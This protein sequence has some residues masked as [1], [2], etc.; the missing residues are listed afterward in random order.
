MTEAILAL[1]AH[2]RKRL[3]GALASGSLSVPCS[4]A[5]IRSEL[6]GR[7]H[8]QEV[9][10][11]LGRMA[12]LGMNGVGCAA[13]I[14]S[15]EDA[16]SRV[17]RPDLV[18]SG[19]EVVG[20]HARD[21]RRVYEELLGGASR[22]IWACSYV[23]FDGPKAFDLLAKRM[24]A[25][26]DL[27]VTLLLNVQRARGDTS[28]PEEVVR[29]FADRLWKR[30]WPGQRTPRVYYDPRSLD[31]SGESSVLHAKAVVTDDESVFIT[32]A[33][34]TEA[35]FDRNIEIGLVV[36]DQSLALSVVSHFRALIEKK[37]LQLLPG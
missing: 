30:D 9:A 20:V 1:P 18:W 12:G 36:R 37:M 23:Y 24:D 7:E 27:D 6:G 2:V 4:P 3:V 13:W 28:A 22:S 25:V 14:Q 29:R 8:A 11:T 31:L 5:A 32:S 33:N 16:A 17:P 10:D 15:V 34:L 21:T 26:P 19:P 35:A